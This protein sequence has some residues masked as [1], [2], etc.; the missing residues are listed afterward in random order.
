MKS[1]QQHIKQ[2]YGSVYR[3]AKELGRTETQLRNWIKKGVEVD[4][5]GRAVH[6]IGKLVKPEQA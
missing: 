3:A 1:L 2:T 6:V 5:K 4:E